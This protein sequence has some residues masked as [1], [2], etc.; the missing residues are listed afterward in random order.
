M[1]LEN[2]L[3]KVYHDKPKHLDYLKNKINKNYFFTFPENKLDEFTTLTKIYAILFSYVFQL[4][5]KSRSS[6]PPNDFLPSFPK[7]SSIN[8]KFQLSTPKIPKNQLSNP[9]NQLLKSKI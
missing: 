5:P 9:K 4:P 8:P 1:A 2:A 3:E 7:I 6:L